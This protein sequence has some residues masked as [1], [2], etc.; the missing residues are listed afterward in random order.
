MDGDFIGIG[1]EETP[2]GFAGASSRVYFPIVDVDED[3]EPCPCGD[4]LD[5]DHC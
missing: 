3:D 2:P 1:R 5:C 4:P